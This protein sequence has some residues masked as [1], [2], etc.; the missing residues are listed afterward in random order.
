MSE[1]E[2]ALRQIAERLEALDKYLQE[3]QEHIAKMKDSLAELEVEIL[4]EEIYE[5][6]ED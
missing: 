2:K 6:L 4:L 3:S 1:E 5:E